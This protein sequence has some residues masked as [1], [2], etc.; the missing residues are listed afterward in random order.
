[1]P[2]PV[3][4]NLS[5]RVTTTGVGFCEPAESL[6]GFAYLMVYHSEGWPWTMILISHQ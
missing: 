1:L 3:R 6:F 2:F 4:G 5:A